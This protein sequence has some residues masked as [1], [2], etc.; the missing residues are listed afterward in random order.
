MIYRVDLSWVV[1]GEGRWEDCGL[2]DAETEEEAMFIVMERWDVR[3]GELKYCRCFP[4][5]PKQ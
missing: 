4:A 5:E 3:S 2:I 1:N